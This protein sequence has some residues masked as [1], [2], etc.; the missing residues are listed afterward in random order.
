MGFLLYYQS[1]VLFVL[2]LMLVNLVINNFV[3]KNVANYSLT[4]QVLKNPPL[5]SILIPA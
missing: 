5:I 2:S 4:G 3:F 1:V